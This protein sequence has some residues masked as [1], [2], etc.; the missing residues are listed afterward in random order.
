MFRANILEND[1]V[2]GITIAENPKR[3]A[4]DNI[5]MSLQATS[6]KNQDLAFASGFNPRDDSLCFKEKAITRKPNQIWCNVWMLSI[7]TL[8][9]RE[10]VSPILKLIREV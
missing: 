6:G 1:F 8:V 2:G 7:Q 3:S 10:L 4:P 5:S 9:Q